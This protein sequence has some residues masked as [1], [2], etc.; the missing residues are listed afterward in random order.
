MLN[1]S[2]LINQLLFVYLK[3]HT[4]AILNE[5]FNLDVITMFQ[6]SSRLFNNKSLGLKC[7]FFFLVSSSSFIVVNMM[8]NKSLYNH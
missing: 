6:L 8:I 2:S 4:Q 7:L 1:Y 5:L 3:N